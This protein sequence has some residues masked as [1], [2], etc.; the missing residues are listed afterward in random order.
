LISSV[1][2]LRVVNR[3]AKKQ[4]GPS[5][6]VVTSEPGPTA[7]YMQNGGLRGQAHLKACHHHTMDEFLE[8]AAIKDSSFDI[9]LHSYYI[10][11][12]DVKKS[13]NRSNRRKV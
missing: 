8:T 5:N 12:P 4:K 6:Q 9:E 3:A 1:P 10:K 2:L 7:L 13:F 11:M